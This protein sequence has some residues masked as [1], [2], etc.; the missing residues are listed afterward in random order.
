MH[1]SRSVHPAIHLLRYALLCSPQ[2]FL[3]REIE[4]FISSTFF[5]LLNSRLSSFDQKAS[6]L[7]VFRS[8]CQDPN[9]MLEVRLLPSARDLPRRLCCTATLP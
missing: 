6:V 2:N 8:V 4:V 7:H 1:G 3:F 9:T 5:R